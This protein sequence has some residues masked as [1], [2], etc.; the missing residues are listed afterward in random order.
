M[1]ESNQILLSIRGLR[2]HFHTYKAVVKA[3][4]GVDLSIQRG[5]TLGLVGESGCGKSVTA[6]AILR[7]IP[8]P[9]GEIV[10]GRILFEGQ[11]ILTKSVSEMR[12]IR[13]QTISMIFQDPMTSLN[14]VFTVGDQIRTVIRL[15]RKLNKREVAE[16][17]ALMFSRV[18]LSDPAATMGKYPHELSGGMCQRVMIA[19][20][21]SCE[22]A[23]LIADEPTTALDVT[24]QAQ[25]LHLMQKLKE[26]LD[27]AIMLITHDLGVIARMCQ[28]VAVMYAGRIV[29]YGT[30]AHIFKAPRHPYTKGLL[31]STPKIGEGKE[32]LETI[33]GNVPDLSR[34]PPG[35]VFGPRCDRFREQCRL[36]VPDSVAVEKGHLVACHR[37]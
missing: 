2:V 3:V 10:A 19:M 8:T 18:G 26:Q 13:G 29:E 9:P 11:E 12:A 30:L 23:L 27:T 37:A 35:C 36:Q 4:Q 31:A 17:A 16:R 22:P 32:R 7:L 24:V 6:A 20:A 14:P 21:L 1:T 15:H 33:K 5:Q 25:I 34:L 28:Q